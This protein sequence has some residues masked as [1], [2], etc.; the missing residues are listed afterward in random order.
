MFKKDL[1]RFFLQLPLDP[2]EYHRVGFLWRGLF[3]FFIGLA[4]GLRHSGLQGQKITDALAWIHRR[5]GLETEKEKLFNLVNYSDNLGG[6]EPDLQRAT[7]SFEKQKVLMDDLG[8]DE[9]CKKVEPPT[10]QMVYLGSCLTASL[11]R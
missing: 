10:T 9:S 11:A 8:V 4:F 1:S 6:V 3:F 7:E 5:L 2:V